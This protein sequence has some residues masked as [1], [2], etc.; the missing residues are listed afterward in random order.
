MPNLQDS[1][2]ER[3]SDQRLIQA[4]ARL[5]PHAFGLSCG[6]VVAVGLFLVTAV[7]LLKGPAAPDAEVGPHLELLGFFVP[8]YTVTWGGALIGT[9][10]GL[11]MGYLFGLVLAGFLNFHHRIYI[12]LVERGVQRQGLL[13]G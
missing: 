13:D 11:L 1:N 5:Q 7:L 8:W 10:W 9:V 6:V 4:F 3:L 12:N 2:G